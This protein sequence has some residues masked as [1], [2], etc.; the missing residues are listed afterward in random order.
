MQHA[1]TKATMCQFSCLKQLL[2]ILRSFVVYLSALQYTLKRKQTDCLVG[3]TVSRRMPNKR[4]SYFVFVGCAMV[5]VV[6]SIL[7]HRT[8]IIAEAWFACHYAECLH[9]LQQGLS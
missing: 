6:W 1:Q 3:F 4:K 8:L 7:L 2:I 9:L 5:A